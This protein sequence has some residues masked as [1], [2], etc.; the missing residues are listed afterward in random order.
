MSFFFNQSNANADPLHSDTV[1][2]KN[3]NESE[4][5]EQN[6]LYIEGF[7]LKCRVNE[8]LEEFDCL[9]DELEGVTLI[10]PKVDSIYE[11][12]I[13]EDIEDIIKQEREKIV[14]KKIFNLH[15][16]RS[17]EHNHLRNEAKIVEESIKKVKVKSYNEVIEE[18]FE[19]CELLS[20][21]FYKNYYNK[22]EV[23]RENNY[24][25]NFSDNF[26]NDMSNIDKSFFVEYLSKLNPESKDMLESEL[27]IENKIGSSGAF[28]PYTKETLKK[29]KELIYNFSIYHPLKNTKTQQI[30]VLGSATLC[31]LRDKIYCVIDEIDDHY[32]TKTSNWSNFNSE[33]SLRKFGSFFFIE[34]SFYND[35]RK[36]NL[37]L[38]SKII[39]VKSDKSTSC[40]TPAVQFSL[41]KSEN[42]RS[43]ICNDLFSK[44]I[45]FNAQDKSFRYYRPQNYCFPITPTGSY[46][47]ITMSGVRVDH[48]IFRVGYPYLFRH[49]EYCDHM[50]ILTD[51]RFFDQYDCNNFASEHNCIEQS[52]VTYQKKLKRRLCD[53]CGYYYSK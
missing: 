15:K 35:L 25:F 39:K 19:N 14:K 49:Q 28:K 41:N 34:N 17:E 3:E 4:I 22:K 29:S 44:G 50:V 8:I 5:Y 33:D 43:V 24:I 23:G 18:K 21:L 20:Y 38:S 7:H 2:R 27:I 45:H 51:I 36:T 1:T 40:Y 37:N 52:V 9:G 32:N 10:P 53:Y 42:N 31:E 47:E 12:S 46:Q 26:L 48:I 6:S 16:D 13:E 30:E 11:K